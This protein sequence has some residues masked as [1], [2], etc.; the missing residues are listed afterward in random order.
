VRNGGIR[1]SVADRGPGIAAEQAQRLFEAYYRSPSTANSGKDG[2]GLGLSIVKSI[3]EAHAGR[4][5]VES[6]K[7]G[8]ARFWF[9]LPTVGAAPAS[10]N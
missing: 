9:E 7:G 10:A 6:R 3:V 5:G 2:V 4:V 1:V 8:G